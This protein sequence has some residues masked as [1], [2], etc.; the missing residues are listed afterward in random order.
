MDLDL[1]ATAQVELGVLGG[2]V[3]RCSILI[4]LL[5]ALKLFKRRVSFNRDVAT[6]SDYCGV[7]LTPTN[8]DTG[9][10]AVLLEN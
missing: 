8:V 9:S 3:R 7:A 1:V 2:A 4:Y 6:F 10:G 5:F